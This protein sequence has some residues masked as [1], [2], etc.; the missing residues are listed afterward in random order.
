MR[1]VRPASSSAAVLPVPSHAHLISGG[2]VGA[3][4]PIAEL[5]TRDDDYLNRCLRAAFRV[6][7]RK[8]TLASGG[9][10]NSAVARTG[11]KGPHLRWS[12]GANR[13]RAVGGLPATWRRFCE[14]GILAPAPTARALCV[15]SRPMNWRQPIDDEQ[16]ETERRRPDAYGWPRSRQR[17]GAC[18]CSLNH[19]H[20][21]R[22]ARPDVHI[23]GLVARPPAW[24]P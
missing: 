12:A 24:L 18:S 16:I 1:V 22:G 19:R 20:W 13:S 3:A 6:R 4:R 21:Q 8:W 2:L 14:S 17:H 10:N 5:H 23:F 11:L 9:A 15:S 7:P